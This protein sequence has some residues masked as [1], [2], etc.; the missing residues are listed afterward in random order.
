M[1][2]DKNKK[3]FWFNLQKFLLIC[4]Y[5]FFRLMRI[6]RKNH[7]SWVVG[8]KEIAANIHHIS[9][10]L[11]NT[12]SVLLYPGRFYQFKY[13]FSYIKYRLLVGPVLLGKLLNQAEGFFYIW[14]K[15]FLMEHL[16][17]S[18]EFEL[19]FIKKKNKKIACF[20]C[21]SEIRSVRLMIEYAK[22]TNLENIATYMPQTNPHVL[23]DYHDQ[24]VK[25]LALVSEKYADIIFNSSMDQ[26]AYFTKPTSGFRYFYPDSKI[27]KHDKKFQNIRLIKI[28]HTPSSPF[29]KGTPLVRAAIK[30]LTEEGY[31]F[32]YVEL[33]GVPNNK[34]LEELQDAH[35]V[36][37]EFYAFV[38]GLFGIEAMA[39]HC[40][41]LT[42]ADKTIE[43][44]LPTGSNE[45]WI[46][47]KYY[48]VYDNLKKLL[49]DP[50][51][52]KPQADAGFKWVLKHASCSS[53]GKKLSEIL[54][55][56]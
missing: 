25:R 44:D 1:V 9:Q 37:N 34:V 35:I 12:Y 18:R 3:L 48:Q 54:E 52:L 53:S 49:D 32:Q 20:F 14:S 26:M 7:Y 39:S 31:E 56:L 27:K 43:T 38:P 46:V 24:R 5:W 51:L 36:L 33:T 4:S 40:A 23:K 21:G 15:G 41:L 45:A 28:V 8:V 47:T 55:K 50:A 17:D 2:S 16:D 19:N 10:S 42:S 11:D 13:D 6:E 29:I 30:K 22:K